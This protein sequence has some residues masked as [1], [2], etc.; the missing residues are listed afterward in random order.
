MPVDSALG[1]LPRVAVL[2]ATHNGCRW[3]AEQLDSV[4]AQTDV[5]VEVFARDDASTDG[6]AQWLAER[7]VSEPRLTVIP[8]D[9]ASGSAATNFYRLI[10]LAPTDFK[11]YA[12]CDQDDIW[13]PTKLASHV[14]LSVAL[15][16][17]GISSN[18]TSFT[19]AGEQSLVRKDFPQ[20]RFD[21]LLESPGPGSTFL[22]SN[23]LLAL[24]RNYLDSPDAA[25]PPQYHDW[26]LYVLAR[27]HGWSWHIDA[28]PTVKYRQHNSNVMGANVGARSAF[29]RL[30]LVRKQ[31]HRGQAQLLTRVALSVAN[32]EQRVELL[33]MRELI[34]HRT[35]R[36]RFALARRAGQ[37]RR[38]PRDQCIIAL[39]IGAGVW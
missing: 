11:F 2:L 4:L 16:V 18:V 21:Y 30:T 25:T 5:E 9:G 1:V 17:D 10:Q 3:L 35:L 19:P 37:L 23:R 8:S 34:D 28:A 24:A 31:W 39:L 7:A 13:E 26:L 20:Q 12:F 32:D 22:M 14:R 38:R 15:A 6:T 29:S 27:A 36:A 33:Q